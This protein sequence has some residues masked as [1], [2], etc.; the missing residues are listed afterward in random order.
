MEFP[1]VR[2]SGNA[3]CPALHLKRSDSCIQGHVPRDNQGPPNFSHTI[4]TTR[5]LNL[6]MYVENK[7]YVSFE[8]VSRLYSGTED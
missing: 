4:P 5:V 3:S 7:I 8:F 2:L 6:F 1:R